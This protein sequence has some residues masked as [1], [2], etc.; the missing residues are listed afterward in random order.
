MFGWD[1][2]FVFLECVWVGVLLPAT[3]RI[4]IG[5]CSSG[6]PVSLAVMYPSDFGLYPH[7]N[8]KINKQRPMWQDEMGGAV[9]WARGL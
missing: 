8:L 6:S 1:F 2:C 5:A 3:K 4:L 9:V 7:P